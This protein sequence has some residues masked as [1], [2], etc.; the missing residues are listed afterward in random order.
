MARER[1]PQCGRDH[2]ADT[3]TCSGCGHPLNGVPLAGEGADTQ[4]PAPSGKPSPELMEWV[5]RQFSE[6]EFL[7]GLREIRETGGRELKDF[8]R[9]LEQEADPRD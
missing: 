8:I 2:P 5:R 4:Q 1:C 9:E 3:A 6:E 7:A